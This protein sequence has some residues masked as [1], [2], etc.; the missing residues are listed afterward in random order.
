MRA[1]LA[2][3]FL[4]VYLIWG[5]TYLAIGIVEQSLPPFFMAGTRFIIAGL[6]LYALMRFTSPTHESSSHWA[7]A[8]MIGGLMLMGGHGAVVWVEQWLPSG[9]TSLLISTV[10]LWIVFTDWIRG[11]SKPNL[12]VAS[13]LFFG[14]A[15]VALLASGVENFGGSQVD[16][17]GGVILVCGAFLWAQGSLVSRSTR[18]PFPPLLAT[19]MQ[20]IAGGV[21]LLVASVAAGEWTRIRLDQVSFNSAIAWL[22]LIVFGSLVGYTSYVWLLKETTPSRVSTYAYVNPIIAM[23]LGWAIAREPIT[24]LNILAAIIILTSVVI[25]TTFGAKTTT[26]QHETKELEH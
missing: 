22:Y 25:I 16:M 12:K 8:F 10:P 26:N 19:A 3:A 21:L 20:M 6:I 7:K 18:F 9:L 1:K 24:P 13:G 5:S 2:A 11:G 4:S 23:F 17:I 14:F 15:G